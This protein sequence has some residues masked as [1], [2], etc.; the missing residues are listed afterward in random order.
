MPYYPVIKL[1]QRQIEY[2]NKFNNN[3]KIKFEKISCLNCSSANQ[4][5]LFTNDRFGLNQK[6]VLC[7]K[8]GLMFLNP[9]MTQNSADFF[10]KSDLYRN[11]YNNDDLGKINSEA[12]EGFEKNPKILLAGGLAYFDIINSLNLKYNSVCDI[13]AGHGFGLKL[14]QL[15]G[16]DVLGYEP[17]EYLC[18]FIKKKGM[19]VINGFIDNVKG[20][21]DL[22]LMIHVLEHLVN[23]IDVLKKLRKHIKKYLFIE[24]PGSINKLQSMHPAHMFHFSLNTLSHIVTKCG[25]KRIYIDYKWSHGRNIDN[26]DMVY[27][28]FEKTDKIE[29]YQ[30][31]Y[32]YEVKK[33]KRIY[34]KYCIKIFIKRVLR[35]ILRKINPNLEKKIVNIIDLRGS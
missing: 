20:E 26:N 5:I 8:C 3:P 2:V 21:Y 17:S 18:N 10:Y 4:K 22:V 24:V 19:N 13:G 7:K 29:T 32:A 35:K 31:N 6:T 1:S 30:Y 16:K 34:Y 27:A 23:P 14:F 25:F 15:A 33:Y 9:R 11:M 12:W 28:L